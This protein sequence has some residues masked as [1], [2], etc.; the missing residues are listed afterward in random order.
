MVP[1]QGAGAPLAEEVEHEAPRVQHPNRVYD[2]M[3]KLHRERLAERG[4][5]PGPASYAHRRIELN[6]LFR[7]TSRAERL[8]LLQGALA[9]PG[10]DAALRADVE[11]TVLHWQRPEARSWAW[12]RSTAALLTYN[13]EWGLLELPLAEGPLPTPEALCRDVRELPAA[14]RLWAA[15]QQRVTQ[16]AEL[17]DAPKWSAALEVCLETLEAQ[18]RLRVHAHCFLEASRPFRVRSADAVAFWASLPVKS[19][20]RHRSHTA[21]RAGA[22]H[23]Y[24]QCPKLGQVWCAGSLQAYRDFAVNPEWITNFVQSGKLTLGDARREYVKCGKNLAHHLRNLALLEE[25]RE[26]LQLEGR[27]QRTLERLQAA[28]RPRR[29]YPLV[30][31]VWLAEQRVEAH[32]QRFLVIQG[33]SGLGKTVYAKNL[34][35]DPALALEVNCANTPEPDLREFRATVHRLVLFD[36]ASP[37]MVL[38]QR[39]LFQACASWVELGC[40][41]TN[42]HAYKVWLHGVLLVVCSNDWSAAVARLEEVDRRWLGANSVVLTVTEPMWVGDP[43]R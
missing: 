14:Q 36:E 27:V 42:C 43:L 41:T 2:L 23:Y 22:G 33:D 3:R 34:L 15:F 35:G 40:S 4:R 30:D 13:G 39:K 26:R 32:R 17:L 7:R 10:L 6:K 9:G 38:R 16:L 19:L 21:A 12:L 1:G 29:H 11:R 31:E 20:D 24:L 28:V 37:Q 25:E 8:G 18:R 5:L